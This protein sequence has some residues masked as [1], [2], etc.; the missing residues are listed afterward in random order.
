MPQEDA[1]QY[2]VALAIALA[3]LFETTGVTTTPRHVVLF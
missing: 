2:K 3:L 1:L